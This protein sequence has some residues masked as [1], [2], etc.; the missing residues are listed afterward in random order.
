MKSSSGMAAF[1]AF[2]AMFVIFVCDNSG[3]V[4]LCFH[5]PD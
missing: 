1:S 5:R 2:S 3:E 4:N